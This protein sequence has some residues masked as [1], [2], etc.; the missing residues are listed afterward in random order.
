MPESFHTRF[1]VSVQVFVVISPKS[2]IARPLWPA[3]DPEG[4][5]SHSIAARFSAF[6]QVFLMIRPK[7]FFARPLR[8]A[9]D[10][11]T[12]PSHSNVAREKKLK[13]SFTSKGDVTPDDSQRRFLAQH[14][15]AIL[16]Q[17]CNHS[18]KCRNNI[19]TLCCPKNHL[20]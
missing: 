9:V 4:S 1:S 20:T 15:A 18:T 14:R 5:S 12:F 6:A 2:F 17:C 10:P 13:H 3:V 8:P 19:A 7:S 11:E 16:E